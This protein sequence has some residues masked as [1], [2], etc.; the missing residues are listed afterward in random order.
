MFGLIGRLVEQKGIDLVI[1]CLPEMLAMDIQF[2]LL[3]SGDKGYE[4]QLRIGQSLSQK[5]GLAPRL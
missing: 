3:G 1:G 4:K 5:N 2:V